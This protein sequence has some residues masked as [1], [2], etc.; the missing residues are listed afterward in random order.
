[1]SENGLWFHSA[2]TLWQPFRGSEDVQM[3]A[4]EHVWIHPSAW[5]HKQVLHHT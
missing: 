2:L 3:L 5:L 4:A 1:M